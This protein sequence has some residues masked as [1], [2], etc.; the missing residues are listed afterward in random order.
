MGCIVSTAATFMQHLC[1]ALNP[2]RKSPPT[3]SVVGASISE[4]P[5]S[6]MSPDIPSASHRGLFSLSQPISR[7]GLADVK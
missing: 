4:E 6:T 7:A 3:G 2:L 1:R 5:P